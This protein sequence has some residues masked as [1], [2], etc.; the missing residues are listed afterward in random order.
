MP[1]RKLVPLLLFGTR[2]EAIKMAPLVHECLRRPETVDPVVC[3]S[4]QHR[5]MRD[6]VVTHFGIEPRRTCA[7]QRAI[8]APNPR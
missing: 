6:Q 2:P 1:A 5:E 4:G 3:L 7:D 8:G